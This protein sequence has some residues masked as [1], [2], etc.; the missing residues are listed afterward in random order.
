MLMDFKPALSEDAAGDQAG[1]L[2]H[3]GLDN[4]SPLLL[5]GEK[6]TELP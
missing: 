2:Q 1:F 6:P 3:G 4:L 5:A